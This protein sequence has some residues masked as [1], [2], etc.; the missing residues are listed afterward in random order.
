[1]QGRYEESLDLY[2]TVIPERDAH[3]NLGVIAESLKDK[4]AAEREFAA[5]RR[6]P[7]SAPSP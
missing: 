4:A 1:M 7:A 2:K 6:Q 5:A 3:Y